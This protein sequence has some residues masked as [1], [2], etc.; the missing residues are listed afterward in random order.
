[1]DEG[2]PRRSMTSVGFIALTVVLLLL[3]AVITGYVLLLPEPLTA[4]EE[5]F[6]GTWKIVVPGNPSTESTLHAD[7]TYS[8]YSS[9]GVKRGYWYVDGRAIRFVEP[10]MQG[11]LGM[12][13]ASMGWNAVELRLPY[14]QIDENRVELGGAGGAP[15]EMTRVRSGAE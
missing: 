1:M 12:A 10:T 3:A 4:I 8:N 15:I 9:G 13:R 2:K 14:K 5:P 11:T 7:R 6:V